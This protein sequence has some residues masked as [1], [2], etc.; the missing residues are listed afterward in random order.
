MVQQKE[1]NNNSHR[2]LMIGS[3]L[4]AQ[5][6]LVWE[7]FTNAD[8]IKNWWGPNGFTNTFH[9]FDFKVGGHWK[10]IMHGPDGTDY[11]N[12]N[13]FREISKNRIVIQH[14]PFPK[15]EMTISLTDV[16]GKTKMDWHMVIESADVYNKIKGYAL[17]GNVQ[18]YDRLETHLATISK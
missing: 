18:N 11:D 1:N 16:G 17:P 7:V 12:E 9:Q 3:L 15:F 10:F 4:N 6:D 13:V 8:H 2:E 5:R 14:L